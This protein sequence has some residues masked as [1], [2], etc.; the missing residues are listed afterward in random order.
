MSRDNWTREQ[1]IVA[2]RTYF[3]VPFNKANN[4]NEE[5]I[6]TSKII[7]RSVNSLK[8]KIGNFGSLDP[9]LAKRGIVGLSSASNL[10][11]EIWH[12][13]ADD[14]EKLAYDSTELIAK[15]SKKK[16]EEVIELE[17]EEIPEGKEKSRLIKTRVNQSFFRDCILGIYDHKC[18]ITGL[19]IPKLLIASHIVPWSVD[20][21]NRLN[22]ENGLC[23]NSIHDKAFDEGLITI[24]TEYKIKISGAFSDFEKEES[25]R[26]FFKDYENSSIIMPER[27]F[28]NKDF[29]KYHQENIFIK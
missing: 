18:C 3:S 11:R 28:P 24:T 25:V 14:R 22:P 26:K 27:Y 29:L 4:S 23:L 8:M 10:D 19:S 21:K 12:E 5:I 20:I 13:F 9:E 15:F 2:L 7:G 17:D 6:S 1:T 16:V